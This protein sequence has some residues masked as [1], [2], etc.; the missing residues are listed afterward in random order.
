MADEPILKSGVSDGN[1]SFE[2]EEPDLSI[3]FLAA[4][5][6]NA[7]GLNIEV[8]VVA[9]MEHAEELAGYQY[10]ELPVRLNHRFYF[11]NDL[12]DCAIYTD[13][14]TYARDL[15]ALSEIALRPH[16]VSF[17]KH[18]TTDADWIDEA[19]K[20]LESTANK[21]RSS[22]LFREASYVSNHDIISMNM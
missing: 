9:F 14:S 7:S 20:F 6:S 5:L 1:S 11:E 16:P 22:V 3:K 4:R 12:I 13:L 2:T 8:P 21:Q 15:I 17:H 18:K 19:R 10:S